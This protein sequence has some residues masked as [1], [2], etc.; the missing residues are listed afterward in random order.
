MEIS[1]FGKAEQFVL[2][3]FPNMERT[4]LSTQTTQINV[5]LLTGFSI[6]IWEVLFHKILEY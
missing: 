6:L 4:I 2:I 5:S 1:N 3:W